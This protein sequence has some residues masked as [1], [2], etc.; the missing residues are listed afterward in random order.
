MSFL[1]RPVFSIDLEDWYQGIEFDFH[2]LAA[3]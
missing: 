2:R 3:I 1:A